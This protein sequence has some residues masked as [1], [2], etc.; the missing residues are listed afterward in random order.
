MKPACGGESGGESAGAGKAVA[1]K[2]V[3]ASFTNAGALKNMVTVVEGA[4]TGAE[5]VG[6]GGEDQEAKLLL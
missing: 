6:R 1:D 2:V 3:C 5:R 4:S